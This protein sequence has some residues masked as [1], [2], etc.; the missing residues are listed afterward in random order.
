MFGLVVVILSFLYYQLVCS[1]ISVAKYQ[2]SNSGKYLMVGIG[3]RCVDPVFFI[4]LVL[5]NAR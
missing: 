4:M 1:T 2:E 3:S 5:Q